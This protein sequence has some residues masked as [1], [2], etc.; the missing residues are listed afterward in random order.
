[1]ERDNKLVILVYPDVEEADKNGISESMYPKLMDHNKNLYNETA[2]A[3]A[4][5]SQVKIVA[6][7]F[8]KT[9]TQKIKRYLYK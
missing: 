3:Y 8:L 9:P 5:I 2:P 6:E 7:P 4:K 1:M